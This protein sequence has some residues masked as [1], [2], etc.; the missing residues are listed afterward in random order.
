MYYAIFFPRWKQ[1]WGLI[2]YVDSSVSWWWVP[3]FILA[4]LQRYY[5]ANLQINGEPNRQITQR[6]HFTWSCCL[7]DGADPSREIVSKHLI[8]AEV[9]QCL[10]KRGNLTFHTST[11]NRCWPFPH[12]CARSHPCWGSRSKQGWGRGSAEMTSARSVPPFTGPPCNLA[13]PPSFLS[14]QLICG[15]C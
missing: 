5:V 1:I 2:L 6:W 15:C 3:K 7:T 9:P 8:P 14:W 4:L 11:V 13:I 10:R 12:S